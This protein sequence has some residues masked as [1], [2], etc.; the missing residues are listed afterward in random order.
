MARREARESNIQV[1]DIHEVNGDVNV[2]AGDI[3]KGFTAEEV[4]VLLKQITSTFEPKTFDGRCPYKGLDVFEEE[5]AELFF[6]RERLKE[7]LISRVKASRTVFISGPSGS[8]K[9]SLVRAG[10]IHALKQGAIKHSHAWLYVTMK[11][12]RDPFEALE[13][14]FSRLK[15]PE[16]GDYFQ[17]NVSKPEILHKC[18]EAILTERSDERLVVFIDQFEEVFTQL[19]SNQAEMFIQ[20][21]NF[22]ATIKNGRIIILFAMRSDFVSDCAAYPELNA[23]LNQQFV[24]IG[25]MQPDELVSAIAQP[26]LRV[27]LKIDPD[28]IAQI[29][30]DMKGEPGALPLMQFALKDLFD[31]GQAQGGISALTLQ[32]YLQRGGI[33]KALERH[34][35]VSFNRL[36]EREQELA[37]SIFSRLIEIG[38]GTQNTRRTANFEELIPANAD[39]EEV[40]AIVRKLADARLIT[41]DEVGGKDTVT[42]SHE[43][44]IDA[45]PWLKKLVNEN[46]EVIALQND[47]AEDARDWDEHNHDSSY[48]YSGARLALAEEQVTDQRLVLSGLAKAFIVEGVKAR[49]T[50]RI[51][52]ERLR[53]RTTAGLVA[54]IAIALVLT[55]FAIYQ[56]VQAQKQASIAF[57]RQLAAQAQ[58]INATISSKQLVGTLLSLQS[59]KLFPTDIAANF[60]LNNNFAA[61]PLARLTH[62]GPVNSVAFSPDGKYVVSASSD[63]TARVWDAAT[64][65]EVAR[66]LHNGPVYSVA[67]SPDSKYVAS[68]SEDHTTRIWEVATGREVARMIHEGPVS[69]VAFSPDGKYVVSLGCDRFDANSGACFLSTVHV[70]EVATSQ[71][72]A[73]VSHNGS[74]YSVAFSPDSKSVAWGGCDQLDVNSGACF[75]GTVHVWMFTTGGEIARMTHTGYVSAIAFSSDGTYVLSGS[76]DGTARVWEAAT[77]KEVARLN[78]GAPVSSVGFSPNN[79]FVVSGSEDAT[80]RVWE[81]ATSKEVAR[82]TH[83]YMVTSVAFS[84]DGEYVV[85]GSEDE[86]A[87]MWEVAT[88]KEV[89]RMTH[90][91]VVTSVAFSQ[92]GDYVV[93]GGVDGTARVWEIG[94]GVEVAHMSND[95]SVYSVAFSPDSKYVVSGSEDHTARVWEI[96]TDREIARLSHDGPV[97]CVAFSPDGKYVA[98]GSWDKTVRVWEAATGKEVAH[99]LHVTPVSSVAFSPDGKYVVSGTYDGVHVWDVATSQETTRIPTDGYVSSVA[100]SPD[101]KYVVSSGGQYRTAYIWEAATGKEISHIIGNGSANSVA[102]SPDGK[103]VVSGSYDGVSVWEV[104][105]GREMAHTPYDNSVESVAFSSD[106]K[107]IV[108]GSWD[109]TVHVWEAATSKEVARLALDGPVYSVAFSSDDKYILSGGYDRT[110]RVWAWQPADLIFTTC[111]NLP[112]NLT[113]AEWIQYIGNALPYQAVCTNLPL[114]PEATATPTQIP[115]LSPESLAT[116]QYF[117]TGTAMASKT[118]LTYST[119]LPADYL[120]KIQTATSTVVK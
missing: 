64:G 15:S 63:K 85:S 30:H 67:F 48:L 50:E 17:Q 3:Y 18:A 87:R 6:G 60:L 117:L 77:G 75:L 95:S 96:A 40:Q 12:G 107:Y 47:I 11:P 90:D 9:S 84:P 106:G 79:K 56:M 99:L 68:G 78:H 10:L 102:F 14:A 54:G 59:M 89:A 81:V 49:D 45:W 66:M 55:A 28:L 16:L 25:A 119:P 5:D 74:V 8:G 62:D 116:L 23:V 109:K 114:E 110:I 58:L 97:H 94:T 27:G 100:F 80:A 29:I 1:G 13:N 37:R 98:S 76:S 35:D 115:S 120:E 44:L 61:H 108:L 38:H 4:S 82:M 86:T 91:G 2:A 20:L 42:I 88:S 71:E 104:A 53:R 33:H 73:R 31:A 92:K 72:V 22:A 69:S 113:R 43:K 57:A 7:D 19:S 105:T 39:S 36:Q 83:V 46:R 93:S 101:G 32:N 70:W 118:P 26:A 111:A 103:H 34:A 112:R 21:L 41:T 24:Q 51:T 52:K 65:N